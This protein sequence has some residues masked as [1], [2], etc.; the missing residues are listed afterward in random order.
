MEVDGVAA[1]GKSR[2]QV[3]GERDG[4]PQSVMLSRMA[5]R[6]TGVSGVAAWRAVAR[7]S[8]ISAWMPTAKRKGKLQPCRTP[9]TSATR[10]SD[11]LRAEY[12][13]GPGYMQTSV[14]AAGFI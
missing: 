11:P 10:A 7:A 8:R 4:V 3:G 2:C 1:P 14:H 13:L 6:P 5:T 9:D 12:S